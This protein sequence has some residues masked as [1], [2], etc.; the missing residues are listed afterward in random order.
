MNDVYVNDLYEDLSD[1]VV[2]LKTLDKI[3]GEGK[4]NWKQVEKNPN[5]IVKKMINANQAVDIG[6][7]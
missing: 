4:V 7:Q 2:L 1:G 3:Y 5:I 6:K